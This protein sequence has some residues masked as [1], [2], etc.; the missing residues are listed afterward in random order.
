MIDLTCP[1]DG[2]AVEGYTLRLE[3]VFVN[4]VRESAVHTTVLKPCGC[5]WIDP[6]I[7]VDHASDELS[8]VDQFSG[9]RILTFKD[10]A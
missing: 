7:D 5:E 2:T 1:N 8:M 6:E 10:A 9:D 3:F 4:G